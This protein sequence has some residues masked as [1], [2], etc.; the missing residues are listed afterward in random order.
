ME[1][2]DIRRFCEENNIELLVL[3]GSHVSGETH[4]E[5]DVD[6]AVKFGEKAEVSKL[7]LIYRLD[8]ILDGKNIDLVILT[9][10]TAP[11]LLYEIFFNG[12]PL[13]E[14]IT[15]IFDAEKLRAW[16]LYIDTK[17]LRAM[18]KKYLKEFTERISNVA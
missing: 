6:V 10:D 14:R 8:N 1:S 11:L 9:S 17:K 15:G 7:E 4:P 18:Q 12:R 3:F 13:Y 5:S 16:K 2:A